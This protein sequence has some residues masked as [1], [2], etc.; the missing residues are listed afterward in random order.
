[1]DALKGLIRKYKNNECTVKERMFARMII[2][3]ALV[4]ALVIF[5]ATADLIVLIYPYLDLITM[6][7]VIGLLIFYVVY[8]LWYFQLWAYGGAD[9]DTRKYY[10]FIENAIFLVVSDIYYVLGVVKPSSKSA[11]SSIGQKTFSKGNWV[12]YQFNMLLSDSSD[13]IDVNDAKAI[14]QNELVR[15]STE[16]FDGIIFDASGFPYLQVDSIVK[17]GSYLQVQM[18]VL[19]NEAEKNNYEKEQEQKRTA[20]SNITEIEDE[21][22]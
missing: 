9:L 4:M 3:L 14:L 20:Q 12:I 2:T 15:K 19:W 7:S 18:I 16:G 8:L 17:D 6:L 10:P 5:D 11:V 13:A 21:V 1:M 22:F